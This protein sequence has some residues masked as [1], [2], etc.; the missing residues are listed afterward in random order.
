LKSRQRRQFWRAGFERTV[1]YLFERGLIGVVKPA[2]RSSRGSAP[3]R[4]K[5][6][7]K[8]SPTSRPSKMLPRRI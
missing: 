4:A 2:V 8:D 3:M 7:R 6:R 1:L 5:P